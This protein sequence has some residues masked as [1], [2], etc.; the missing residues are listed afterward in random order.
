[1]FVWFLPCRS[2]NSK[3]IP[4]ITKPRNVRKRLVFLSGDCSM[5]SFNAAEEEELFSLSALLN[6]RNGC[7]FS[8]HSIKPSVLSTGRT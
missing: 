2:A 4:E 5:N 8:T 1:M 7:A 6:S 3:R